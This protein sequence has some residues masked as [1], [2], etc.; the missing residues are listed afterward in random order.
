MADVQTEHDLS[1]EFGTPNFCRFESGHDHNSHPTEDMKGNERPRWS[2][3][4]VLRMLDM[5]DQGMTDRQ[6][7]AALCRTAHSVMSKRRRLGAVRSMSDRESLDLR[8]A[9]MRRKA[10]ED[11]RDEQRRKLDCMHNPFERI[12]KHR[13]R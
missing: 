3:E 10:R 11:R 4:E 5:I 13:T 9:Y 12:S 6:I 8:Y 7:G 2:N 1:K